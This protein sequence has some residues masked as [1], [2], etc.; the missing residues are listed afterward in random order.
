MRHLTSAI[1]VDLPWSPRCSFNTH[2]PASSNVP[3]ASDPWPGVPGPPPPRSSR[4]RG[5][6]ARPCHP[7]PV[8]GTRCLLG[9]RLCSGAC[10]P[11][12]GTLLFFIGLF[13]PV[14]FHYHSRDAL[15][16]PELYWPDPGRPRGRR[17]ACGPSASLW[18]TALHGE[19]HH[20]QEP[21]PPLPPLPRALLPLLGAGTGRG[22]ACSAHGGPGV[23]PKLYF[24]LVALESSTTIFYQNPMYRFLLFVD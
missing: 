24:F 5:R 13:S 18:Q 7:S 4:A 1:Q 21:S 8:A 17:S 2:T 9:G 14:T 6:S 12:A 15:E 11:P 22:P 23:P 3:P 16:L 19:D 20:L 10:F